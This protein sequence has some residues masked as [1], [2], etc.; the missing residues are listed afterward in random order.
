[1]KF[2]KKI[3]GEIDL[4]WK[5]LIIFAIAAGV[6][7]AIMAIL[8]IARETSFADITISFEVWI[9]F[10]IF[11]IM[12]S[13]SAKESSL[14]CF[15]FF[16]ISQPLI[17]LIQIPF[18]WMGASLFKYYG[19]WFIWTLL[20]IPMGFIGFYMKKDKWWG[21]LILT[22]ILIFLGYHYYM[23]LGETVYYFPHHLISTIFCFV[24]LLLYPLCI[25]NNKTVRNIGII[26]SSLII[27]A[28]TIISLKNKTVYNTT[29]LVSGG[30]YEVTFDNKYNVYLKNTKYGKVYIEYNEA[31]EDYMVNAEF[32]HGGKTELIL[33]SPEGEKTVFEIN[34]E[35][36]R[37]DLIKK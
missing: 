35:R 12:N 37:Y 16:L 17:Y 31:L 29:V 22:P 15:I 1:M 24:T 36:T 6:Y 28:A 33:E 13:K 8:P 20:T 3:F 11:I 26:I 19:Y 9:L 14:K 25:F 5:K 4:T 21:L 10:G 7:T 18:S 23:Y 27:I 34:I 2:F 32:T 30:K